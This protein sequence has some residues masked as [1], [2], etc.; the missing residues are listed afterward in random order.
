MSALRFSGLQ[1]CVSGDLRRNEDKILG[2]LK[3]AAQDKADF[4]LTPEGSLS[5]Y[6][7]IGEY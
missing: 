1:M 7:F 5:G 4:L 3:L 2:A 6:Y